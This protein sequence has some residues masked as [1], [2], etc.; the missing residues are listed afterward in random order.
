[1]PCHQ[2]T[3]ALPDYPATG[4]QRGVESCHTPLRVDPLICWN[5]FVRILRGRGRDRNAMRQQHAREIAGYVAPAVERLVFPFDVRP[6]AIA[7]AELCLEVCA[8]LLVQLPC[9]TVRIDE[10]E[11]VGL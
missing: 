5:W 6:V 11:A 3:S 1:M 10:D 4:L 8:L 9:R 7:A 2:A